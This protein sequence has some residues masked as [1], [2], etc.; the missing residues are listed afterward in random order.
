MQK[1]IL[2]VDDDPL[3][4]QSLSFNL[5]QAGFAVQSAPDAEEML[6]LIARSLPMLVLLDLGLP[7]MD[8]LELL[9]KIRGQVPVLIVTARQRHLDEILGLELGAEDYV[10]KPFEFDVLLARIRNI[11]RREQT[12][13]PNQTNLLTAG[14]LSIDLSA[15]SVYLANRSITLSPREFRLLHIL[16]SHTNHV[17][18][19]DELLGKV[20]GEE[21]LGEPQIIY[22]YIRSLREKL[23]DDPQNPKRLL[24]IRGVGYKLIS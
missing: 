14:E 20:W 4:R 6:A 5:Q 2:V 9:R 7:G 24:T 16:A 3:M 18:S 15:H 11:L 13:M 17:L 12:V 22:V 8:G 10:T 23:E 21:F 1:Y 19:T